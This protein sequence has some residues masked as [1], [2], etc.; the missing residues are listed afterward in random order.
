[1]GNK[2]KYTRE[3]LEPLVAKVLSMG[4]LLDVIGL[5][6]S[7]GNYSHLKWVIADHGISTEHWLGRR[8]WKGKV[9]GPRKSPSE[10]LVKRETHRPRVHGNRLRA[11]LLDAGIAE[12]CASCGLGPEWQGQR[13]N[14]PVDHIDGDWHNNEAGNLQ[15]LCPNCHSQ[16]ST[17]S[18]RGRKKK[19]MVH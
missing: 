10:L 19:V 13:L 9:L 1:M 11:G 18:G 4:E 7:G 6:R 17:F 5:R 14:L 2:I 12:K 8:W 16:T 15:F 3:Y